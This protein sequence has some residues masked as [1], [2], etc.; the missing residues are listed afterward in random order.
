MSYQV[1]S[2]IIQVL[3]KRIDIFNR[4]NKDKDST[5]SDRTSASLGAEVLDI[6]KQGGHCIIPLY[7]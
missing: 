7:P 3:I 4:P 1:T 6:Y 2:R 5:K